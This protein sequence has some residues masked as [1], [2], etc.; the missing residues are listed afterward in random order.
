MNGMPVC[1]PTV[2]PFRVWLLALSSFTS[3]RCPKDDA[4]GTTRYSMYLTAP[5]L[6][7]I[8]PRRN[9]RGR[10]AKERERVALD[11][12]PCDSTVAPIRVSGSPSKG[13]DQGR[14]D[15]GRVLPSGSSIY[16]VNL[17][18]RMVADKIRGTRNLGV[19]SPR[20]MSSWI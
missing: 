11:V 9:R 1:R 7:T 16:H 3:V 18:W 4:K 20:K 6:C 8:G 14:F 19:T 5:R 15:N 10:R 12:D 17:V 2:A 13:Y